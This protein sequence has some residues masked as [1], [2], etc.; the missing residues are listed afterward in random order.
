MIR[1]NAVG[2]IFLGDYTITLGHGVGSSIKKYG[3]E[4]NLRHVSNCLQE[5]DIVFGNLET[6]LSN[7]GKRRR[8]YGPR[9]PGG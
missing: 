8:T 1:I 4:H 6:V 9:L 7:I 2:D 5:A 3:Y